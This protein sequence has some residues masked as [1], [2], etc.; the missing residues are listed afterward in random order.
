MSHFTPIVNKAFG[1]M[2]YD[3]S[4]SKNYN[5]CKYTAEEAI[6]EIEEEQFDEYKDVKMEFH[7]NQ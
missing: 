7:P 3:K 4:M 2:E 6:K 5:Y 1:N